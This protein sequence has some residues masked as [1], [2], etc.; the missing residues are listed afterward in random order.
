M[1]MPHRSFILAGLG[2]FEY[3]LLAEELQAEPVYVINNGV[4]H[5]ESVPVSEIRPYIQETLDALEFVTGHATSKWGA[6]RASMG[7]KSPWKLKY[8]AIGNE[9][10]CPA[11]VAFYN[12]A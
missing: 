12:N 11:L 6:V 10:I 5:Q 9:V 4:S 1:D 7:R 2:L 8:L 3:M